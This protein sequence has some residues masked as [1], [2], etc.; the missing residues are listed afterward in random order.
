MIGRIA[1]TPLMLP[2]KN[3]KISSLP[4][5]QLTYCVEETSCRTGYA[6]TVPSLRSIV[7]ATG[8]LFYTVAR[9]QG[10]ACLAA[11]CRGPRCQ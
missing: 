8:R 3:L 7:D 5:D 4:L 11:V 10:V 9:V 6:T 2:V 1:F